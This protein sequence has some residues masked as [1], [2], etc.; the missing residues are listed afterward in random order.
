MHEFKNILFVSQ[1]LPET[2]D[3]LQQAMTLAQRNNASLKGLIVCPKLPA[4]MSQYQDTYQQSLIN[5]LNQQINQ[6]GQSS[7]L[8]QTLPLTVDI[9]S[10]DKPI[11]D[12]I[13]Y[14]EQHN[15][16]L[17]IKNAEPL[18]EGSEGFKA[19]DMKLLRKCPCPVWLNRTTTIPHRHK[20]VAVAI[21]PI[22]TCD[23]EE[24]L[25]LRLLTLARNIADSCNSRLHI[26]SCWEYKLESYLRHNPWIQVD[27]QQLNTD[28]AAL[29]DHHRQQLD[30]L[31]ADSGI[32]G[33]MIVHHINGRADDEIPRC[34]ATL[35]IDILVMG[36]IA[37]TGI[38]GLVMGNT[39]ENI[40]QS[41]SCSLVA[42]KPAGF[43]SPIR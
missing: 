1:G 11:V 30:R 31:V 2:G 25:A 12:V 22:I 42:L 19:L 43:V 23:E 17:L 16:D 9:S 27:D 37:R 39:A 36:T 34:A 38:E 15:R 20:C 6:I 40:L 14:V 28:I 41:L 21:D 26:I 29:R 7:D 33:E 24:Q 8:T 4:N 3:S 5:N 13:Q 32:A 18:G 35:A 10:G